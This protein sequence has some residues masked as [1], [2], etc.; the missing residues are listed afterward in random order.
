MILPLREMLKKENIVRVNITLIQA[1]CGSERFDGIS[2]TKLKL[3]YAN[4][5]ISFK[6]NR[7][8]TNTNL[9]NQIWRLRSNSKL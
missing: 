2:E 5:Q 6:H 7:S 3:R 8:K 9:S 4:H 1:I